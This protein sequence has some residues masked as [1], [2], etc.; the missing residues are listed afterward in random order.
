MQAIDTR[1]GQE[2]P[3]IGDG[4]MGPESIE[5]WIEHSAF[6]GL[7]VQEDYLAVATIDR[8]M[9]YQMNQDGVYELQLSTDRHLDHD[10]IIQTY[11]QPGALKRAQ[12]LY[13]GTN[14][15]LC[16]FLTEENYPTCDFYVLAYGG[17]NA[18][19]EITFI[20]FRSSLETGV[21]EEDDTYRISPIGRDPMKIWKEPK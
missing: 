3:L 17:S 13:D 21:N 14:L 6:D 11:V 4:L 5:E 10:P 15:I 16:D 19:P 7:L 18:H 1:D 12:V 9:V 2:I 20:R 8:M